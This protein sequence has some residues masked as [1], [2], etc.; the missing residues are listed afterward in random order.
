MEEPRIHVGLTRRIRNEDGMV[1]DVTVN[2]SAIPATAS[3]QFI[4]DM[5]GRA[6]FALRVVTEEVER[7]LRDSVTPRPVPAPTVN[8]DAFAPRSPEDPPASAG[9]P[10]VVPVPPTQGSE[11]GRLAEIRAEFDVL[12][13]LP[14]DEIDP[15]KVLAVGEALRDHL[16]E[17]AKRLDDALQI[18]KAV[19][20]TPSDEI[21]I[22]DTETGEVPLPNPPQVS[23]ELKAELDRIAAELA[24]REDE[25]EAWDE[26][27]I[28]LGGKAFG[29][30]VPFPP[31]EWTRWEITREGGEGDGGQLK[32]CNAALTSLGFGGKLRHAATL[33]ILA[34][35]GP[36]HEVP[37]RDYVASLND[38]TKAEAHVILSWIEGAERRP[39]ALAELATA[40]CMVRPKE[41]TLV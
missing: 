35:Y 16:A 32:A 8:F 24:E 23:P 15:N 31:I 2:L 7:R 13:S 25:T 27:D 19:T 11:G 14:E 5:M 34:A 39:E 26:D 28:V 30:F 33:A 1:S 21:I 3:D 22:V 6:D 37:A 20:D 4:R 41:K 40:V 38:L 36:I 12:R 18:A 10:A 17:G 9:S 29:I